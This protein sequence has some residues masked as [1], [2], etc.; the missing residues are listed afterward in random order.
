MWSVSSIAEVVGTFRRR[1]GVKKSG[2]SVPEAFD[3]TLGG[4][5]E[6]GLELGEELLDRIKVG[7]IGRQ[8][9][10]SCT[11]SFY[12]L[13]AAE[14]AASVALRVASTTMFI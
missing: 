8:V 6:Q 14:P 5:S 13:G 10:Q 9:E 7:R 3:G 2:N 11:S 12:R 1:E 4:F